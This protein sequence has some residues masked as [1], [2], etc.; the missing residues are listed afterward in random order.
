M[1]VSKALEEV[2]RWKDAVYEDIKEMTRAE[3]IAYFKGAQAR[4]EEKTGTKLHLPRRRREATP[5]G[6]RAPGR[7]AAV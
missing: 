5:A 3:R 7:D 2:W 1:K 6:K 4:L